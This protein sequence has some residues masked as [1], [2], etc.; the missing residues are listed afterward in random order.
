MRAHGHLEQWTAGEKSDALS[1][2]CWRWATRICWQSGW[3]ADQ[4]FKNQ[5]L[6]TSHI[7]PITSNH[8]EQW[9]KVGSRWIA[10]ASWLVHIQIWKTSALSSCVSLPKISRSPILLQSR[11]RG[12]WKRSVKLSLS[13]HIVHELWTLKNWQ[14]TSWKVTKC[15]SIQQAQKI[16]VNLHLIENCNWKALCE[17]QSPLQMLVIVCFN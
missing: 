1:D 12:N 2:T 7:S 14:L 4:L 6:C 13:W 9:H 5:I 15:P 11:V 8:L 3:G 10:L 17:L 16:R